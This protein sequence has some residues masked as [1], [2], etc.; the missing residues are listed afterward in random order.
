MRVAAVQMKISTDRMDNVRKA[1]DYI[2]KARE[3]GA[4]LVCFP[5]GQLGPYVPQYP[6]LDK[7]TFAVTLDG[8]EV[9]ALRQVC[10]EYSVLAS[11]GLCLEI[12]GKVYATNTLVGDDGEILAVARKNHIVQAPHFYEQDYFEPGNE[13]FPVVETSI[14]A[15]GLMVCF[16]RH[17][18]E[19][20]RTLA[21]KGSELVI[22]PVANEKAE[23]GDVFQWEMR[24]PAFQNSMYT[25]MIN[26]VGVEGTMDFSG[27][28]VCAGPDG[29]IVAL[30]GDQE[31]LIL[32]D[33]D[34]DRCR[35][36]REEK[37][38]IPLRRPEVFELGNLIG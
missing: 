26:R 30:A 11:L 25:L 12:D 18:P 10:R 8:P 20:F 19:S 33:L 29:K 16:D 22:V 6:G 2:R 38:Y 21:L 23:P 32:M 37:Q 31:E 17:F 9:T 4:Q 35:A 15:I 36:L 13:G 28:T 14:G 27:E 1:V 7:S 3:Q 34:R 5:E 24:I